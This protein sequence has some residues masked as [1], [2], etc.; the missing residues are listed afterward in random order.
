MGAIR[1][2]GGWIGKTPPLP[3]P[4]RGGE[5]DRPRAAPLRNFPPRAGEGK[6]GVP[7]QLYSD[8]IGRGPGPDCAFLFCMTSAA[9]MAGTQM[10]AATKNVSSMART[11]AVWAT[12]R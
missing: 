2:F 7:Q 8:R 4:A 12:V 5:K 11:A 1:T 9:R 3:S 10:T 6:G